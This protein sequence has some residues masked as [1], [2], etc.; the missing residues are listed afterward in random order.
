MFVVTGATGRTGSAVVEGLRRAQ[1]R[2]RALVRSDA[3]R[4]D[5]VEVVSAQLD[6]RDALERAF[7]DAQGVYAIV[8]ENPRATDVHGPRRAIAEAIAEAVTRARVPHVVLLSA[9]PALLADGNGLAADLHYAEDLL[10][11]CGTRVTI[12]RA[13]WF[14]DNLLAT[15]PLA[16]ERGIHPGMMPDAGRRFP[17][18]AARDVGQIAA[19][20]LLDPP[21]RT[22]IVDVLGPTY[23]MRELVAGLARAVERDVELVEIP[24]AARIEVLMQSG[25]SAAFA[26]AV[27]ELFACLDRVVPAGDRRELGTTTLAEVL[28]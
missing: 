6:D 26:A 25:C 15:L 23:S 7:T 28:R 9:L 13:C 3:P 2:V 16:R 27:C 12:L 8:P 19:R 1:R 18:I 14:L 11:G 22:E 20:C 4:S 10:R 24:A 5:G 17:T 21:A